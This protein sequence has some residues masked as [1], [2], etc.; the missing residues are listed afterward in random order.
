MKEYLIRKYK[1]SKPGFKLAAVLPCAIPVRV[2]QLKVLLSEE[3]EYP[4]GGEFC[5]RAVQAG[6]R[7]TSEISTFLGIEQEIA[8][9]FIASEI[10]LGHLYFDSDNKL[11]L[12]ES[13]YDALEHL[14]IQRLRSTTISAQVDQSTGLS[15]SYLQLADKLGDLSVL[16]GGEVSPDESIYLLEAPSRDRPTRDFFD[17]HVLNSYQHDEKTKIVEIQG[18]VRN[19]KF[20]ARLKLC[21]LLSYSEYGSGE[22]TSELYVDGE[23]SE[24][25]QE[26]VNSFNFL[27]SAGI[28]F[29]DPVEAPAI[30]EFIRGFN[31]QDSPDAGK[32]VEIYRGLDYVE[33]DS[34]DPRSSTLAPS[35][36]ELRN[37]PI[38]VGKF[39]V[40]GDA[41]S[42]VSVFEHPKILDEALRFSKSRLFI[43]S[44]WI[45]HRVVNK[46]FVENLKRC[47]KRGVDVTIVYGF[48]EGA[49]NSR[50]SLLSLLELKSIGLKFLRHQN[51][52]AKVLIV[53]NTV[54]MTSF[55]WLS[56]MG[57]KGQT[58]RMEEGMEIRSKEFAD[59]FYSDLQKQMGREAQL[60][61]EAMI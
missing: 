10:L 43:V 2:F 59:T 19:R 55:N 1:D 14:A 54:V 27:K 16:T 41:P 35:P 15:S 5:L 58:Y 46:V 49:G 26:F 25:H 32:I 60:V 13:G 24:E 44:P 8:G 45:T 37:T 9:E 22:I 48:E 56:F 23:I 47:I 34:F 51:T 40:Q 21:W 17:L 18:L 7:S 61:D 20:Q 29:E 6:V 39:L 30:V 11:T 28:E 50:S 38:G 12:T 52:H 33:E 4:L 42:R 3:R 31:L 36:A 53:D 57:D